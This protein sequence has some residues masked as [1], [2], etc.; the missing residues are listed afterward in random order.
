MMGRW[1]QRFATTIERPVL[2][3]GAALIA[4]AGAVIAH[5]G[6]GLFMENA[7]NYMAFY[8]AVLFATLV[9]G[10]RGGLFATA[11][12]GFAV[13]LFWMPETPH[14]AWV[15]EQVRLIMFAVTAS[16]TV[17]LA[18]AIRVA[19]R[20][21]ADA[22]ERFRIFQEQALDAFVIL[23]PVYDQDGAI[24]DFVWSYANPAAVRTTPAGVNDLT[25]RRVLDVFPDETGAAMVERLAGVLE[26]EG[27]DDIEVRRVIDGHER[28]M[29]SSAVKLTE[30]LAVTFRDV[31]A[32]RQSENALRAGETR[33]RAL[34]DSLPQLI[35]SNRSNGYCDYLS[36]QWIAFTGKRPS[37]HVGDGWLEAVH[38]EDRDG[39]QQAWS[40]AVTGG[41]PFDIEYRIRRHDGSYRWFNGKA[42]AIREPDGAIR[43]WFGA[44]T[45][46]TEIV[47]ARSD[48]EAR[49]AE[50]TREL[51][52]SL[53][54]RARA[55]AALAQAQ[56]LETVGRLTGGV[57][58]DFN[59]L[60]TVVIG[61]LDMILKHPE[62]TERVTRLSEAALAAGRRGER[63]TRQLLAFSRRQELKLEVVDIGAL[64]HQIE[65]LV[66][67]AVG[68]AIALTLRCDSDVGASRLDAAQFEAAL[69]NLVV[70]A[71]DAVA[72]GH[73][74]IEIA[75]TR[76]ALG[77]GEVTG[78][79]AREY[80]AVTVADTG[81]GMAPDTLQ[82][83]FEPF[84][85]T[86][87]VGKGT[88]LGLAQVYGF[89]NQ[90]GGAVTIDSEIGRGTTVTLYLPAAE[91][92]AEV[93]RAPAAVVDERWAK[94]SR[95]L[96][97][98]DDAA[99]RAVFESLLTDLGCRVESAQDAASA[100]IR[101]HAG[102]GFDLLI[103]DIVMPGGMSGV[104]LARAAHA[105]YPDLPIVLTTGYAGDRLGVEPETLS[106]P[107][108]RK[109]FRVEQLGMAV[110]EALACAGAPAA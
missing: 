70:N 78:A 5:A 32:Q 100:L 54:E 55:E 29:R 85:T 11:V 31:S 67:R 9:A 92:G 6:A 38:P 105:R 74:A 25:G 89:V 65:P 109:P 17:F 58:H 83:A 95:V 88:G 93:E 35:W 64:I 21:G 12:S 84:F 59:N 77:E 8:P 33:V 36:P 110:R 16:A 81:G 108:L 69:L 73:G 1:A 30:G 97:V 47:E 60:L 80:I 34:V 99:V 40:Q 76:R 102:E 98:E 46:I 23:E 7:P 75:A 48:L 94:G 14:A 87:D 68:E 61:G 101:L 2:A 20:R 52:E 66:R 62:D 18:K 41:L 50:R 37:E 27:P 42:S 82:R 26:S 107:V 53:E 19:V 10:A 3:Y 56:R 79:A 72:G 90:V 24:A 86:K 28:F 4:V 39:V 51:Q 22:E 43:R 49:V 44:S 106:W 15:A 13:W 63:L 45:D 103:S 71:T 91:M 57:A 96:L 104:D